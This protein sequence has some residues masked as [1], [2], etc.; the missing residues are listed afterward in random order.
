MT[1]ALPSPNLTPLRAKERDTNGTNPKQ[2]NK[3][4]ELAI[5]EAESLTNSGA[6]KMCTILCKKKKKTEQKNIDTHMYI[7]KTRLHC[8]TPETKTTL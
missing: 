4:E 3:W 5:H 7:C 6:W 8:C 2:Y 1:M